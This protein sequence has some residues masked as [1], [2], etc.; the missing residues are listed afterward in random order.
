MIV[1]YPEIEGAT[2]IKGQV[3]L[4]GNTYNLLVGGTIEVSEETARKF[5]STFP[6]LKLYPKEDW[7]I[8]QDET[9]EIEEPK[10]GLVDQ[11]EKEEPKETKELNLDEAS[12][13][14]LQA[15]AKELEIKANQSPA[16]LK[17]QIKA[18]LE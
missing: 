4:Q 15:K 18:R 7:K 16:A 5:K 6:F 9:E 3:D 2:D 10:K 8:K 17:E 14:E 1:Y 12:Y 11:M 13:K